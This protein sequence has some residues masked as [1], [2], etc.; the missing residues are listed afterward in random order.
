MVSAATSTATA[1]AAPYSF[2]ANGIPGLTGGYAYPPGSSMTQFMDNI[3]GI[4]A[5][6][7]R[8]ADGQD[9]ISWANGLAQ[10]AAQRKQ[11]GAAVGQ[12]NPAVG[13]AAGNPMEQILQML[14]MLLSGMGTQQ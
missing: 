1:A 2:N 6:A 4:T 9:V 7:T 12:Q 13:G 5:S 8:G 11:Q 14:M 3:N 10:Q